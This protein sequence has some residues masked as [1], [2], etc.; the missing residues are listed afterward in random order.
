MVSAAFTPLLQALQ[1]AVTPGRRVVLKGRRSPKEAR[2]A[3]SPGG[4][5]IKKHFS[6][7]TRTIQMSSSRSQDLL[8][9]EEIKTVRSF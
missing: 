5:V 6:A 3:A 9:S 4:I 1:S 2:S 7:G 8:T